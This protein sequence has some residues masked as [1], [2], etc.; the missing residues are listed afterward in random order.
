VPGTWEEHGATITVDAQGL[1]GTRAVTPTPPPGTTRVVAVGDSFTFGSE[2]SDGTIWPDRLA[3][4]RPDLD[5]VNL[6]VFGYGLDQ[7]WLRWRDVGRPLGGAIV[8]IAFIDDDFRRTVLDFHVYERPLVPAEDGV[9]DPVNT[10]LPTWE[11]ERARI[12]WT[13]RLWMLAKMAWTGKAAR[14]FRAGVRRGGAILDHLVDEVRA[15]GGTPVLVHLPT[16]WDL[17]QRRS[18]VAADYDT[19]ERGWFL[20]RCRQGDVPCLDLLPPVL[21]DVAAGGDVTAIIHYNERGNDLVAREIADGL[22]RAGLI[23]A[24]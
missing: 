1:R 20:A 13:P 8:L 15:S 17:D 23:P 19:P 3:A 18:T 2:G 12:A 5:V 11:Q 14:D 22:T 6:G 9:F 21:A 7:M 4:L 10:P 16:G 24:R